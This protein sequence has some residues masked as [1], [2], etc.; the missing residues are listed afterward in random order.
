[1]QAIISLSDLRRKKPK[2]SNFLT[3]FDNFNYFVDNYRFFFK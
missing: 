1:M 2:F 3:L